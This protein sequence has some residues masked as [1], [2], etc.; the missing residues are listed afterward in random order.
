MS[1]VTNPPPEV[2]PEKITLV[3]K[4]MQVILIELEFSCLFVFLFVSRKGN[5]NSPFIPHLGEYV[6]IFSLSSN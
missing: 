4:N 6:V 5:T 2:L 1:A 3:F